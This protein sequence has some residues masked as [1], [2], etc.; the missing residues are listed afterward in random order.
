MKNSVLALSFVLAALIPPVS[1]A[2]SLPTV[3]VAQLEVP[4]EVWLDSK[5]EAIQQSTVSAQ[6]GGQ[7]EEIFYDV[8]DYVQQGSLLVQ[9]RDSEQKSQL[10]KAEAGQAEAKA[11]LK[12]SQ[13]NHQRINELYAKKQVS[14]AEMDEATANLE[15]AKARMDAAEASLEQAKE[16]LAYTQVKA[17]YSGILTQRHVELGEVA[18][19]G[20]PLMTGV[21]L[22]RLRTLVDVPQ[23][24]I[25][26]VRKEGR[27]KIRLT[28]GTKVDATKLTVFP[29][30]DHGSNTFKVRVDLPQ[31]TPG[32]FPGMF[33]KTGFI[34]G[35]HSY[36][37]MPKE[38]LVYRGE[39]SGAYIE[40]DKGRIG[41]RHLRPGPE[42]DNG[43]VAI[44]AGLE[45]GEKVVTD[46]IAAGVML[47]SQRQ[48]ARNGD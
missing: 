37:V 18:Q 35:S 21:S 46:P 17:P 19:P 26:Q 40:D 48:E 4:R 6:T 1:Q 15:A 28:D 32:L 33:V 38:A 13:D 25:A 20:M 43:Q 29:F 45:A 9:L 11:G 23:S 31:A 44:L 34:L 22:D 5:V 41:F 14:Q 10:S 24:L 8:D 12:R 42:L 39:V 7:V 36:L 27:A 30:A 2:T 47:K 16:Q 3:A